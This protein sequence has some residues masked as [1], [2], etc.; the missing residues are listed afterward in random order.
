MSA[1][2]A[3]NPDVGTEPDYLPLIV[4]AGVLLLQANYIT[5]LYLDNHSFYPETDVWLGCKV[6]SIVVNPVTQ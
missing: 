1:F 2:K 4:A 6:G 5:R 3:L